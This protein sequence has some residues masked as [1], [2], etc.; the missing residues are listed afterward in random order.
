MDRSLSQTLNFELA[1]RRTQADVPHHGFVRHPFEAELIGTDLANWLSTIQTEIQTG[2]FRL[3]SHLLVNALKPN[4]AIRPGSCLRPSDSTV[5]SALVGVAFPYIQAAL[6]WAQDTVD[7]S[8]RLSENHGETQWIRDTMGGWRRF[9][10]ETLRHLETD[11]THVLF[12]DVTG[13]YENVSLEILASD[14]RQL[15]V[16][17]NVVVALS[18]MLN[19]W[20]QSPARSIPQGH[21]ASDILGKVYLNPVDESLRNRGATHVRYVDD[22][23]IF[24]RSENDA[25]HQL[26]LL[27]QD[28]RTRGLSLQTAKTEILDIDT[29]RLKIEE[30]TR[31]IHETRH[32]FVERARELFL[33]SEY[34]PLYE[35]EALISGSENI[36]ETPIVVIREAFD[37]HYI[38]NYEQTSFNKSLFHFLINRLRHVGDSHAADRCFELLALQPQET[39]NILTYLEQTTGVPFWDE[40][41]SAFFDSADAIYNYQIYEML[42]WRYR[43]DTRLADGL[44]AHCRT[45][46]F[47]NNRPGY[48]RSFARALLARNASIADLERFMQTYPSANSDLEQ[49]ELLC[50]LSSL[51]TQ[52]RNSFVSRVRGDNRLNE[53]ARNRLR[54]QPEANA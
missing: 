47:D 43:D 23:R 16:P 9:E 45:L 53:L 17:D 20:A 24:A 18:G 52:R 12:T 26:L 11:F 2:N 3:G 33:V 21:S 4:G 34:P 28:L 1:W 42:E 19:R 38:N 41:I 48:L 8:Y 35:I 6:A 10:T 36:N 40:R 51:E 54:N 15:G 27:A 22:F 44:L 46:A 50:C 39:S 32:Q 7:F 29:A 30:L 13:Y 5:Y 37:R 14:L 49:A 31:L 25:K